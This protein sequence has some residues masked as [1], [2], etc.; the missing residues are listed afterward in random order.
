MGRSADDAHA[1][2]SRLSAARISSGLAAI[3]AATVGSGMAAGAMCVIAAPSSSPL[4][5]ATSAIARSL[6]TAGNKLAMCKAARRVAAE[7]RDEGQVLVSKAPVLARLRALGAGL[8][9]SRSA[10]VPETAMAGR[11]GRHLAAYGRASRSECQPR[12]AGN[13]TGRDGRPQQDSNL[14][15]RL[16]RPLLYP[17]SYGGWRCLARMR[18]IPGRSKSTSHKYLRTRRRSARKSAAKPI[19]SRP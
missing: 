10:Y 3:G 1:R 2:V 15:T 19:T 4:S 9:V 11:L 17:L 6:R 16:R 7:P 18:R 5:S 13:W 14:R 12:S 8:G